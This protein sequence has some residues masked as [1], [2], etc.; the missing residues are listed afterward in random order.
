MKRQVFFSFHYGKDVMRVQQ[1]RQMG[2]LDGNEPVSPNDWETVKRSGDAAIKR[3]IDSAMHY[4]S[5]VIVLI[6]EETASRPWVR[7][8]IEKAWRDGKVLLGIYIHN[9][10]DPRTGTCRKGINPFNGITINGKNL[11]Q[12]VKCYDPNPWDAY[13]DIRYNLDK[14][15]EDAQM[16]K[17]LYRG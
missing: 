11:G 1:I 2:V 10:K 7:Y 9:L 12:F 16:L 3:W 6:G 17:Y 14:W 4:R 5:T 13:N 8:E 15:V